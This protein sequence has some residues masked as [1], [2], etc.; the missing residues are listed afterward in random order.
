MFG[1][2]DLQKIG[3]AAL[4]VNMPNQQEVCIYD[5]GP[6]ESGEKNVDCY[7]LEEAMY[8]RRAGYILVQKV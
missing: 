4:F 5:P 2:S 8:Q 3:H 6:R 7:R 1:K